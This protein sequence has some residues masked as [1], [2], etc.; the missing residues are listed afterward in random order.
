M[1][2][3]SLTIALQ[4]VSPMVAG[5]WEVPPTVFRMG[6]DSRQEGLGRGTQ[7]GEA[8]CRAAAS[9][10]D[11]A[12]PSR[13]SS[14]DVTH[15]PLGTFG[16]HAFPWNEVIGMPGTQGVTEAWACGASTPAFREKWRRLSPRLSGR[17]KIPN[18]PT[19]FRIFHVNQSGRNLYRN[20][21]GGA[22][23]ILFSPTT[24]I[25]NQFHSWKHM[26]LRPFF[27]NWGSVEKNGNFHPHLGDLGQV[28]SP[29][30]ALVGSLSVGGHVPASQIRWLSSRANFVPGTY[31]EPHERDSN[32]ILQMVGIFWSRWLKIVFCVFVLF[33]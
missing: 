19:Q 14:Q 17:K 20:F 2:E 22:G 10:S 25:P 15:Q 28:T 29:L 16:V 9:I 11:R 26:C 30:W 5:L 27:L 4:S 32:N 31:Q 18:S 3:R 24:E 6:K 33:F 8:S 1:G 23:G 12:H 13:P 7:N 21:W